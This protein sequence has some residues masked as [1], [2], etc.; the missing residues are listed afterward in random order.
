MLLKNS[1]SLVF[2][3]KR[4]AAMRGVFDVEDKQASPE[5]LPE[6]KSFFDAVPYADDNDA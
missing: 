2:R 1:S 3:S 6:A 4:L 5:E